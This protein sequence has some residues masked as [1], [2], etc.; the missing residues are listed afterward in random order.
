MKREVL[1]LF[2]LAG[3]ICIIFFIT[4]FVLIYRP[5][6]PDNEKLLYLLIGTLIGL[7]NGAVLGLMNTIYNYYYGSSAK[8]QNNEVKP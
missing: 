2:I 5:L 4:L 1:Y 3:A 8:S 7:V 6:P